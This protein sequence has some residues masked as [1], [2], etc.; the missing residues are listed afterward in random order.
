LTA[1]GE[2]DK[3]LDDQKVRAAREDVLRAD[4]G[5]AGIGQGVGAAEAQE[6]KRQLRREEAARRSREQ[7]LEEARR[8]REAQER[9]RRAQE[10]AERQ[11]SS[12]RAAEAGNGRSEP[13]GAREASDRPSNAHDRAAEALQ[14]QREVA[15]REAREGCYR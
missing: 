9:A 8:E 7:A 13:Q 14:T 5:Q 12:T 3:R 11:Q 6:A 10:A 2:K 15:Q 4:A 1:P